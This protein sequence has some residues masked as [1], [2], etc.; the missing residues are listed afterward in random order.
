[1]LLWITI[2]FLLA[3]GVLLL[4]YKR[5]WEHAD[6]YVMEGT[7]HQAFISVIIPARNEEKNIGS[8]LLSLQQQSYPKEL[9]EIIVVDDYSSDNT[10]CV[11][12]SF[13]LPNLHLTAPQI[14]N[15]NSSK[16]KAIEAGIRQAKG[17]LIVTTD[18]DCQ[19]PVNWL[20]TISSFYNDKKASFI[21]APVKFSHD[22][23]FLQ[24]FQALDF[25][26]L[27]GITAASV[28]SG[29]HNMCNGANLAYRKESFEDVNG[30]EGIDQVASGDDMLLM[31][32]IW[33]KD[34]R[35]VYYLKSREAIVSTQPML[36]I[37]SFYNQRKRWASKTMVY[38]DYRILAVL[39]FIYLLNCL[40]IVLLITAA[41]HPVNALYALGFLIVKTLI[42]WPFVSSVAR[43]Y[44]EQPLMKYFPLFQPLH[45]IYTVVVGF[46]SQLGSY[47]WKGRRTK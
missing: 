36:S 21:A 16:K 38:K 9:F 13:E 2:V 24:I 30:F 20:S 17:E 3:Y 28:S 6:D 25:I 45:I 4:F 39:A 41:W 10:A 11:V 40:F 15:N 19:L 26:T 8:L 14:T 33:K 34:P 42:E 29:F 22:N 27:Q 46:A 5:A 18:A 37:R 23:S 32:K 1:M 12:R 43:F 44:S 47:E 7:G 31:H 35:G